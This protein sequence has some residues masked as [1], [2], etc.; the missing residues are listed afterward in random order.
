MAKKMFTLHTKMHY[1]IK[2]KAEARASSDLQKDPQN[3]HFGVCLNHNYQHYLRF[4]NAE[5]SDIKFSL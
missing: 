4:T 2:D 1:L 3:S 5:K